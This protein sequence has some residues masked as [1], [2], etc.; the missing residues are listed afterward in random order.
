MCG[1]MIAFQMSDCWKVMSVA[2]SNYLLVMIGG[3]DSAVQIS[4]ELRP[5]SC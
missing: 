3:V 4:V 2:L 5:A 1:A